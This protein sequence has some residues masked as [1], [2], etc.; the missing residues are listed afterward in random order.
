MG[1]NYIKSEGGSG[2]K[3]GHSNMNHREH[4][5]DIKVLSKKKR[6]V[7]DKKAARNVEE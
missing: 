6:R 4:T 5:E 2:G 1:N 3:R 7:L